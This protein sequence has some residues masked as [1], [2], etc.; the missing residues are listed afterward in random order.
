MAVTAH[1]ASQRAIDPHD[2]PLSLRL[3]RGGF[4]S[5]R[6]VSR[7]L[8]AR[9]VAH[10]FVKPRRHPVPERERAI[11]AR[12]VRSEVLYGDKRIAVWTFEPDAEAGTSR[13][14][15]LL[16]H[17]W[18]GRGGQLG[19]WVEPLRAAGYSVVT[20]DHVG[21]G[22]SDGQR[23]SLPTMRNT[24]RCVAKA[25][26]PEGCDGPAALVAHSMGTFA[27][28]LLLADGWRKTRVVYLSPPD[29]LLVYF[30]RYLELVTGSDELLPDLIRLM[31]ERFGE[32]ADEFQFH[33]L[34]ETLDQ[35]L[36]ILHSIDDLD[37]PIEGGRYVAAHWPGASLREVDG[38]GHRKILQ[39]PGVVADGVAFLTQPAPGR[40]VE[41][42]HE[43]DS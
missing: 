7:G 13:G 42:P 37:V 33:K 20:F 16:V 35:P 1:P 38:L 43:G 31:E 8:A 2:L 32:R 39:D 21:H 28:S 17:G 27:S 24:L 10:L 25:V 15:A 19:A 40:P 18:E 22:E 26:L 30:A 12:G 5:L 6:F 9:L 36:R 4:R 41:R 3:M 23:C 29:D 14:A 34:V 11:L